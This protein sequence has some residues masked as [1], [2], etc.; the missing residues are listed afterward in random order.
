V[1][2]IARVVFCELIRQD[3]DQ[4]SDEDNLGK[5]D[6]NDPIISIVHRRDHI[7]VG[8]KSPNL[9]IESKAI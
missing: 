7:R 3:R 1:V 5:A 6:E 4:D 2:L 9:C 8:P